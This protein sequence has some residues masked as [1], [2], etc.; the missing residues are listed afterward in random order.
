MNRI[1]QTF[2]AVGVVL[3]PAAFGQATRTW[4]SGVGDDANPCSRTAP[5]K[6]FA[7]AISK[8]ATS[9]EI[10]VLDPGGFGALTITKSI[11]IDGGDNIGGVLVS[12]TNGITIAAPS[13]DV[14]LRHLDIDGLTTG[15]DGVQIQ[16]ASAVHIDDSRIFE[17]TGNGISVEAAGA[18]VSMTDVTI[19]DCA[20]AGSAA[21]AV[22]VAATV[23][24]DNLVV[25]NCNDGLS[26]SSGEVTARNVDLSQNITGVVANGSALVN[27]DSGDVAYCTTA[28]LSQASA[29]IRISNMSILDNTTGLSES[30]GA[31]VSF[32][33]NRILGNTTN[34]A[35]TQSVYQR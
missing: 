14:T 32:V 2:L 4:V 3:A 23:A 33:N 35:P 11:T 27:L 5:C 18:N 24:I 25:H 28:L 19:H 9:G 17:F 8:T 6:T 16:S 10:D 1:V 13:S 29:T 26:A 20:G 7:G 30:G 34:G 12:G 22:T 15:L 21:V 31:I